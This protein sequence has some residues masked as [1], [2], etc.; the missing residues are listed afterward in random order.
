MIL[1]RAEVVELT[2]RVRYRAQVRVLEQMGVPFKQRLDGSI[3]IVRVHIQPRAPEPEREPSHWCDENIVKLPI[4]WFESNWHH[5]IVP[6]ARIV[7]EARPWREVGDGE[8][9]AIYALVLEQ[10]ITYVGRSNCVPRRLDQHFEGGKQFERAWVFRDFP[11]GHVSDLE[12]LY[13]NGLMPPGNGR[14]PPCYK[15]DKKRAARLFE[16]EA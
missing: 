9:E 6:R 7:S 13:I 10:E 5:L 14:I 12:S 16:G 15:G 4:G 11:H 3:V 8:G 1:N 2:G